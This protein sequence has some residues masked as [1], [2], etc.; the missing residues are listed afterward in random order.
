MYGMI[1][2]RNSNSGGRYDTV[3][4]IIRLLIVIIK[5]DAVEFCVQR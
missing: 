5:Y 3:M 2:A 1:P 4:I